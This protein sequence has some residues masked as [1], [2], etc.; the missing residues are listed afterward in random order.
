MNKKQFDDL[1]KRN[2]VK[3]K[4]EEVFGYEI[5]GKL[6]ENYYNVKAFEKFVSEMKNT[7]H[8]FP[9]CRIMWS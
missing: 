4:G 1:I 8:N 3:V 2:I 7:L 9:K 6:Y 5:N